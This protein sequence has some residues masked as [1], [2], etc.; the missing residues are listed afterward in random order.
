MRVG[1]DH[2]GSM[3]NVLV[4]AY[5]AG[6]LPNMLLF[7]RDPNPLWQ[8]V[9]GEGFASEITTVLVGATCL[10]LAVPLSTWLATLLLRPART[11]ADEGGHRVNSRTERSVRET[12][13]RLTTGVPRRPAPHPTPGR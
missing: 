4:L 5:A 8:K 9:N 12:W 10:L 3:V 13:G 1:F 6:A 2:I 11:D 7:M